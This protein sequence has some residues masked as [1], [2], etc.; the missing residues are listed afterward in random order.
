MN[1]KNLKPGQETLISEH[2]GVKVI[3]E[4][5]GNGKVVRYVRISGRSYETIKTL[6]WLEI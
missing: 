6:S 3:A 1:I 2:K 5:S 4:R